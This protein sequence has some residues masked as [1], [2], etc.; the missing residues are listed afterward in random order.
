MLDLPCGIWTFRTSQQKVC[1]CVNYIDK[2]RLTLYTSARLAAPYPKS[3]A[4]PVRALSGCL[5]S[6]Y[7]A[8]TRQPV[9]QLEAIIGRVLASSNLCNKASF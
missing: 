9:L 5:A 7:S 8:C 6:P 2:R 3:P 1:K 4:G